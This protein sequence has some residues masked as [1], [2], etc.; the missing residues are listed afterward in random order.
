MQAVRD[1]T[2]KVWPNVRALAQDLGEDYDTARKWIQRE[3]IPE[4]VWPVIIRKSAAMGR[5]VTAEQLL[6]IN[7]PRKKRAK[8]INS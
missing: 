2:S 3:R 6:T 1:I 4:R 7:S 5:P 8:T